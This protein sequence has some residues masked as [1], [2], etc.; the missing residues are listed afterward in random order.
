[1]ER[2]HIGRGLILRQK[3]KNTI[4]IIQ[5]LRKLLVRHFTQMRWYTIALFMLLY[6]VSS[7][8]FLSLA[9]ETELLSS[10]DFVYWLVVTGSTVGY[11]DMSPTTDAGKYIVALYIIPMGLSIF[12]F[13]LGRVAAWVSD[14]WHKRA[15][16]MK[17]LHVD[18]HILLIGWNGERTMQL[19][20]LL[21]REQVALE[22]SQ[23]IVLCVK[24]DVENPMP[25]KIEFVKV[26]S[27]NKDEDMDKA[28]IGAASVVIVDNPQDDLTMTTSLYVSQRNPNSHILAYFQDE[29][30]VKLLTQ[31]CPNVECMPSV[32]VEMLAK[33]AFDPG[34]SVLHHD[35]LSV[36]EGQAQYSVKVPDDIQKTNVENVFLHLKQQYDATFIG[37]AKSQNLKD[38]ELNPSLDTPIGGGDKLYY[39]AERR[40]LNINWTSLY[41]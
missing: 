13:V 2:P 38:I 28:C 3:N 18:N 31:H 17:E 35:L 10:T 8:W 33:S 37:L 7:W 5:K 11:G 16:G 40:I 39:I 12:A 21:L 1:M 32:A 29:S 23:P 15:R 34:S 26:T 22:E 4:L 30:L 20:R 36:E 25:G 14:Q 24:V 9:G 19:L 27:F 41:V 6:G